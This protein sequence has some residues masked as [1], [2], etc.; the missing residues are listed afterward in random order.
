MNDSM[1]TTLIAKTSWFA[2]RLL[3]AT[4]LV[5]TACGGCGEDTNEEDM[6]IVVEDMS[7]GVDMTP[8]EDMTPAEDMTPEEDMTPP[9]EDMAPPV[10]DMGPPPGDDVKPLTFSVYPP[11]PTSCDEP[12]VN[13]R[14]PFAIIAEKREDG[15]RRPLRPGDRIA[16]RTLIPNETVT[17]GA[18]LAERTRIAAETESACQTNADCEA[19]FKCAS[20]GVREASKVCTR[21]TGLSFVPDSVAFDY[22]PG[23]GDRRQIVSVLVENSGSLQGYLP[24]EVGELYGEDG[25][26]DLFAQDARATDGDLSSRDAVKEFLTFLASYIDPASSR[27]SV[28]WFA[29]D[30]PVR[31]V[32][33]TNEGESEDFYTA[34]LTDPI[35]KIANL[36]TP[37]A[38]LGTGNVY[39][40]ITRVISKD[41]SLAKYADYEK[42]L[43]VIVDGPNEVFDSNAT[44]EKILEM[45]EEHGI[46]LF[47]IHFDA[48]IDTTLVRDPLAYWAGSKLCRDDETCM[49]APPCGSDADCENFEE[50]RAAKIYPADQAGTITTTPLPYCLPKYRDDGRLGPNN[51]Y[52][53]LACRTGGNYFYFSNARAMVQPLKEIPAALDGQWSIESEISYLDLNRVSAGFYRLSGVFLG[54][55][56][57]SALGSELSSDIF[58]PDPNDPM[59]TRLLT[60]D[61][62][63]VIRLGVPE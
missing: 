4:F 44:K 34:D 27:L 22:D 39:Q 50:C 24:K 54:L 17:V 30:T 5:M 62:R 49:G 56:G 26:K 58:E 29:G 12:N 21:Q 55:F 15:F 45:L 10:E 2:A 3:P 37:S 9:E 13:Y 61:N 8:Q 7:P 38:N 40:A 16:G 63:P 28:W 11:I 53:D 19:G 52:A 51:A 23:D 42:H 18:L 59:S 35:D 33:I 36:P 14:I 57:N 43:F 25:M 48:A 1:P 47:I 41:M 32:A 60:R 46:H 6:T 31:T 20:G